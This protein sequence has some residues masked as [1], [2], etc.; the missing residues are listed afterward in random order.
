ME[1]SGL[2]PCSGAALCSSDD[3]TGS[4]RAV[5]QQQG[6]VFLQA[7]FSFGLTAFILVRSRAEPLDEMARRNLGK[8]A[9][10]TVLFILIALVC[11]SMFL[12]PRNRPVVLLPA[13]LY[14]LMSAVFLSLGIQFFVF[15][16]WGKT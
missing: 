11:I 5:R 6:N 10:G 13:Y 15:D 2:F 14:F 3:S 1:H 16:K 12:D 4:R 9:Y 8:A 7:A